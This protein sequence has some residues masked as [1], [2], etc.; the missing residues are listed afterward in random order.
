VQGQRRTQVSTLLRRQWHSAAVLICKLKVSVE[1]PCCQQRRRIPNLASLLENGVL[2]ADRGCTGST[3]T[4]SIAM[5]LGN[6]RKHAED[7]IIV[8]HAVTHNGV[9][10][11]KLAPPWMAA[12]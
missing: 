1:V 7:P 10:L 8:L 5:L 11:S 9:A 2:R 3:I 4:A 6:Y 12:R